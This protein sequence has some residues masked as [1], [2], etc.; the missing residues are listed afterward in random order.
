VPIL[1]RPVREQLEHD[2]VIRALQ[3]KWKRRFDVVTNI[4]E[5]RNASVK[6]GGLML[7]PDLVLYATDR[8]RRLHAVVEVETGESV[9]HLEAMAQWANLGKV[10]SA[11]YLYV[12]ANTSDIARRLI[13][14]NAAAV[15][16]LWS[17]H[18]IGDQIRF[19][20]VSRA[21]APAAR[22]EEAR[23][24]ATTRRAAKPARAVKRAPRTRAAALR[25]A[26]GA[27]SSSRGAKAGRVK[28]TRR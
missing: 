15:T 6:S 19:T 20:M 3:A 16:E 4:G 8:G 18:G 5:E 21:A 28:R 14:D 1:V 11:F 26:Q 7:F 12:P 22:R 24:R 27:P 25:Q 9:N 2:R 10:R 17:F 13:A 23:P